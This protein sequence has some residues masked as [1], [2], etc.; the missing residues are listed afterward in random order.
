MVGVTEGEL[1]SNV[2]YE[3]EPSGFQANRAY[4]I[5]DIKQIIVAGK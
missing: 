3:G 2:D 5:R 4:L 1:H